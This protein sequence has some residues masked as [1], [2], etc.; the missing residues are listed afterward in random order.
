MP[1][2][3]PVT[4]PEDE[5]TV[6]TDVVPLVHVPPETVLDKVIVK[7][8]QTLDDPLMVPADGAALIVTG[9]ITLH[10]VLSV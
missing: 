4:T 8:V 3:T 5:P 1:A 2:A 9:D 7:P 10:P 6:A